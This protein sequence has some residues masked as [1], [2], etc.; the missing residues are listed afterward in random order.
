MT[1]CPH[2]DKRFCPLYVAAHDPS[3]PFGCDDGE[4]ATGS[5]AATRGMDYY[6]QIERM[7]VLHPLIVEQCAWNLAAEAR[8][9]RQA[10]NM[11]LN[12]IH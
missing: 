1:D 9:E 7:R 5:C 12:G 6:A 2:Y 11:G 3:V 10:R 8:R 4:L